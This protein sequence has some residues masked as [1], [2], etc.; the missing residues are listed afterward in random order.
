[1]IFCSASGH[2]SHGE[3]PDIGVDLF[4]RLE[5]RLSRKYVNPNR[6]SSLVTDAVL[7]AARARKQA[8]ADRLREAEQADPSL[9]GWDQEYDAALT[10]HRSAERRL[11]ALERLR[12]A[13]VERGGLRDAAVK[14][15][16]KDLKAIASGLAASRDRV[17]AAA[18]QHLQA[19]AALA[20]AVGDH[21]RLL[22]EGRA[23]V[24]AFGLQ[25]RDDLVDEHEEHPEGI[26]DRAALRAGGT[27]WTPVPAGGLEA[28][29]MRLVFGGYSAVH[30]LAQVG[31]YQWRP[32]ELGARPD[33]LRVPQ[34]ADAGPVPPG[35][36]RVVMPD[37][38][39]IK[40]GMP[41]PVVTMT[42]SRWRPSMMASR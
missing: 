15:A 12:A 26:L 39:S 14:S 40:D 37:R 16:D 33:G 18:Q 3:G 8:A 4:R 6:P 27:D 36:A 13:Q 1:M 24:A 21:N 2:A 41:E 19:L 35:P 23:K 17:A 20:S 10:A 25:V 29:A 42:D 11:E 31:R 32:H 38:P 7:E 5:A 30:P 22:A 28:H 34:L 9:R